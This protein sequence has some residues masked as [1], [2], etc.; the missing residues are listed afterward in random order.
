MRRSIARGRVFPQGY[1]T[2]RRYGRLSLK[3]CTLF[4]LMWANADDQGRLCGDP[5]EIKYAVCPNIDHIT[6][7]DI[8]VLLQELA[9]NGL[10]K[11]YKTS[12]TEAIQLLDWW[13]QLL[14]QRP[15]WAYP[16]HYP[17]PEGWKDRLRFHPTPTEIVTENW[18]PPGQFE[19]ELPSELPRPSKKG[20]RRKLRSD[21]SEGLP[22]ELGSTK[23]KLPQTPYT[24][25]ENRKEKKE[26]GKGKVP[27]ELGSS[28][29]PLSSSPS[30]SDRGRRIYDYLKE[31][32][33]QRWGSVRADKPNVIIHRQLG[34]K[35]GAQLRELAIEL[36][37][38]GV[39]PDSMVIQYAF[40]E[41]AAGQKYSINY[42]RAVLLAK[43]GIERSRSP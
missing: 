22:S 24:K 26:K 10:I 36:S 23:K 32:Y 38:A 14:G 17:P 7:A 15:Q 34:A 31:N 21:Q 1:S 42:V 18:V 19:R 13:H 2:D 25:N 27:S 5:E 12:Q 30:L 29:R 9:Q 35:A 40:D 16:S 6:K 28:S 4:P 41:A 33:R 20:I 8:P 37:D 43:L 3:A 39:D 11:V